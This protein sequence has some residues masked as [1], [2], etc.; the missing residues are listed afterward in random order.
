MESAFDSRSLTKTHDILLIIAFIGFGVLTAAAVLDHGY[1]GIVLLATKT[2]GGLQVFVDLV[3]S[4]ILVLCWVRYD[5]KRNDRV[6]WPW[7]L[8]TLGF[9]VFDPLLYLLTRK[10]RSGAEANGKAAPTS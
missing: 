10:R 2:W 8:I 4:L 9:G 1:A 7:L 6:F 3:L 5:S